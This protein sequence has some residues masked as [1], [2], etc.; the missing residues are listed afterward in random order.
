MKTTL[1]IERAFSA[2]F[3]L[4]ALSMAVLGII[5]MQW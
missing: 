3:T 5:V 1:A 4:G 2:G